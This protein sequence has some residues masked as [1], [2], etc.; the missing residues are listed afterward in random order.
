MPYDQMNFPVIMG[1]VLGPAELPILNVASKLPKYKM[2]M[3]L[4]KNRWI[5]PMEC[6]IPYNQMR[7]PY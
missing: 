6:G 2:N 1:H 3:A 7:Y 5:V 4:G